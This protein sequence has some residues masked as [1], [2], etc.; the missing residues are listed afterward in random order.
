MVKTK[1]SQSQPPFIQYLPVLVLLVLVLFA[2]KQFRKFE[3]VTKER[4]GVTE[5]HPERLKELRE[6]QRELE[7]EYICYKLVTNGPGMYECFNCETKKFFLRKGEV[8]KYGTTLHP[9]TRYTQKELWQKN[10]S[11]IELDRGSLTRMRQLELELIY[12]YP[13][14]EENLTRQ[15]KEEYTAKII[16]GKRPYPRYRLARPPLNKRDN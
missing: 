13:L 12:M 10:L 9:S 8:A 6:K 2:S 4:D 16:E 14:L 11:M 7:E 3:D 15:T 5:L 1:R